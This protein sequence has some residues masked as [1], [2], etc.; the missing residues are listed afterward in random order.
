MFL[1]ISIELSLRAVSPITA[2]LMLWLNMCLYLWLNKFP[3]NKCYVFWFIFFPFYCLVF[4][5][6]VAAG[7]VVVLF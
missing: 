4:F 1:C 2:D 3:V 7:V 6:V 5:V